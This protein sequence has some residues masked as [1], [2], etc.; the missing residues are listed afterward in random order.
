MILNQWL[1]HREL[2]MPNVTG[3]DEVGTVAALALQ[4]GGEIHV[5][6]NQGSS[7]SRKGRP[8]SK[9]ARCEKQIAADNL[10]SSKYAGLVS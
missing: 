2:A 6:L 1:W 8:N 3:Q 10:F 4:P 9:L 7:L 5:D